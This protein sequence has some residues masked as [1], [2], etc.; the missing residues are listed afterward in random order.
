MKETA[1]STGQ[2]ARAVGIREPQLQDI[3][4]R[5][6]ID[7]PPPILAGRRVW[8][9]DNVEQVRQYLAEREQLI[10]STGVKK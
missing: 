7:P 4:R 6:K 2:A 3:L 5:G 1:M 8:S 10:C 9:E